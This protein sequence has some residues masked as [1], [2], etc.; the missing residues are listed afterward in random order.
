M[1]YTKY[2]EAI[3]IDAVKHSESL[4]GV[5]RYLGLKQA[6]GTQANIKRRI[7]IY[8]IDTSHFKG[9]SHQKNRL[10]FN[11]KHW[12]EHLVKRTDGQRTRASILRRCLLE[13][14]VTY[15]CQQCGNTGDWQGIE[16]ILEVDHINGDFT[17]NRKQNLQFLCPNCHSQK[18]IERHGQTY[19]S[20]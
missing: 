19:M 10:A 18:S 1:S 11:K 8:G 16:L 2:T 4:A 17:D 9:Q 3:L 12:S 7:E 20:K 6:G 14:G 13:S 5:L 15:Q